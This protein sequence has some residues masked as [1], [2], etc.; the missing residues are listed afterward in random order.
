MNVEH[1][2]EARRR[3][4]FREVMQIETMIRG[5]KESAAALQSDVVA[6]EKRVGICDRQNAD[7]PILARV[8]TVRHENLKTTIATLEHRVRTLRQFFPAHDAA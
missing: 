5:M 7:Y 1:Q 6:E 3:S 2:F 4:V 8:L